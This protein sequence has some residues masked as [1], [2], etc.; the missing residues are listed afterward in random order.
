MEDSNKPNAKVRKPIVD[1][2][3][4]NSALNALS[5]ALSGPRGAKKQEKEAEKMKRREERRAKT[6][7]VLHTG[8]T[9]TK[10]INSQWSPKVALQR[11]V[12]AIKDG[13]EAS[14]LQ[15][16]EA[17][18]KVAPWHKVKEAVI[19][20]AKAKGVDPDVLTVGLNCDRVPEP[21]GG[22]EE[23]EEATPKGPRAPKVRPAKGGKRSTKAA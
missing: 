5:T 2:K 13:A 4:A 14:D 6:L 3:M 23:D 22:Q 20:F 17:L 16:C 11:A 1:K 8:K 10:A 15:K 21:E 7:R 19:T 12:S 9:G 18:Q